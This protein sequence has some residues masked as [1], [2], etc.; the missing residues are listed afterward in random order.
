M[1]HST[2]TAPQTELDLTYKHRYNVALPDAYENLLAD[3]IQ[4]DHSNFVRRHCG[5]RTHRRHSHTRVRSRTTPSAALCSD[6]LEAAWRIFTPL[7]HQIDAKLIK[8]FP[9]GCSFGLQPHLR[10]DCA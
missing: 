8:P 2:Q 6:E 9:Y 1:H 7:L 4:G 3:V 10:R 5:T